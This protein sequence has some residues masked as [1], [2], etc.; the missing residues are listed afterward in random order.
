MNQTFVMWF[1]G[2]EG[3]TF[4]AAGL[5]LCGGSHLFNETYSPKK[6]E[7][8]NTSVSPRAFTL[9]PSILVYCLYFVYRA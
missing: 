6:E 8:G 3:E 2:E 4:V 1:I 7:L 9:V 5:D